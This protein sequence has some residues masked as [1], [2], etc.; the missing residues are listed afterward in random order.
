MERQYELVH[1]FTACLFM[2]KYLI[3]N[4]YR[5]IGYWFGLWRCRFVNCNFSLGLLYHSNLYTLAQNS[6]VFV[7]KVQIEPADYAVV[8]EEREKR[9]QY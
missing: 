7:G 3:W 6:R 5:K 8:I 2:L 1:F 4:I 9:T